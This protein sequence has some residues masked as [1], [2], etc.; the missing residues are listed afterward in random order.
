MQG[1]ENWWIWGLINLGA[2]FVGYLIWRLFGARVDGSP[3]QML[4]P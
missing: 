3:G 1:S 2:P 4:P